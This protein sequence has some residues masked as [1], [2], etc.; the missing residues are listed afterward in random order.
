MKAKKGFTTVELIVTI[1]VAVAFL[2]TAYQLYGLAM[3]NDGEARSSARASAS[4]YS[5]LVRYAHNVSYAKTPC[6][7]STPVDGDSVTVDGLSQ[8][9]LTV[10]VSCTPNTSTT[11]VSKVTAT[12][13]YNVDQSV[14]YVTYVKN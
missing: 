6:A 1:I 14:T 12:L 11:D 3:S 7:S 10:T 2:V 9:T 13:N 5:Y 8:P 4:A